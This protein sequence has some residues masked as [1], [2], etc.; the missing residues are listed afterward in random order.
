MTSAFEMGQG[1]CFDCKRWCRKPAQQAAA[2]ACLEAYQIICTCFADQGTFAVSPAARLLVVVC[3]NQEA[4]CSLTA[5]AALIRP[6]YV[7]TRAQRLLETHKGQW[8]LR[9]CDMSLTKGALTTQ[10]TRLIKKRG[11][12]LI[13]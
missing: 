3:S 10:G 7:A 4:Y 2:A 11:H 12:Q 1:G 6:D 9:T 5:A 13:N 8:M